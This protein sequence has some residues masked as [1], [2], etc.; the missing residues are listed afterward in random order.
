MCFLVLCFSFHELGVYDLPAVID[1]IL[2]ITEYSKLDV[3][4]YSLGATVS[5]ACLSD[6]PE[7]NDKINKLALIAPATNFATS[8]VAAVVKQF[9][10]ILLVI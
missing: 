2:K 1:F 5:F 6:K 7:Y 9:S 8:P 3:V 4:G 10:E